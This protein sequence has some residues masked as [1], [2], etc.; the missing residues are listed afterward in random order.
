MDL[1][2]EKIKTKMTFHVM[3]TRSMTRTVLRPIATSNPS[4]KPLPRMNT[5]IMQMIQ[6]KLGEMTKDKLEEE[7]NCGECLIGNFA[8]SSR[9]RVHF[10]MKPGAVQ[11]APIDF[12]ILHSVIFAESSIVELT[13]TTEMNDLFRL[14]HFARNHSGGFRWPNFNGIKLIRLPDDYFD[15]QTHKAG[16]MAELAFTV[17]RNAEYGIVDTFVEA[18]HI[19]ECLLD[20]CARDAFECR[21]GDN[22]IEPDEGL[23]MD[24]L[25]DL[26]GLDYY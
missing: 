17:E 15:N 19:K 12:I 11:L 5:D 9:G 4:N 14:Y 20:W 3:Q 16:A 22:E 2:D 10:E 6:D 25:A 26:D 18:K 13:N 7:T 8:Y 24:W 1:S 21:A 23:F